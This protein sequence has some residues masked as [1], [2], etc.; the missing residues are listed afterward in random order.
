MDE[1]GVVAMMI[2]V[3]YL[4]EV[5][6]SFLVGRGRLRGCWWVVGDSGVSEEGVRVRGTCC[7]GRSVYIE[8]VRWRKG[9]GRCIEGG[10]CETGRVGRSALAAMGITRGVGEGKALAGV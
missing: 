7:R 8:V 10:I 6:A 1:V 9:R 4:G 3:G 5:A 2:E